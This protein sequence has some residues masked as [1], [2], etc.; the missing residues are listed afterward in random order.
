M[1]YT[2]PVIALT[3]N[4]VAGS[5]EMFLANGFDG[6]IS[7]PIDIRE[8]NA[9]LNRFIRD[10]QPPEV[11]EAARQAQEKITS[12][13]P[14]MDNMLAATVVRSVESSVI[15]LEKI[16][17][18]IVSQNDADIE[19]YTITVHGIKGAL[20]IIGELDLA[21]TAQNLEQAGDVKDIAVI[22]SDTPAFI[23][24]LRLLVT[25]YK[26]KDKTETA[27]ISDD[28]KA[29]LQEKLNF[30]KEACGLFNISDAEAALNDLK[31]KVW[32]R[33]VNDFLEE[34]AENVLCGK[35]KEVIKTI[36]DYINTITKG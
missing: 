13:K 35:L 16:C 2:Y 7:K 3:A 28:D 4:A 32:P 25:K 34:T 19:L 18:D 11:I 29:F 5:S 30:I 24:A 14:A 8:L 33:A 36:D 23:D 21:N 6:F 31:L 20:A 26:P 22:L 15:V 27:E 9:Q 10:R 1:G 17:K 12:K